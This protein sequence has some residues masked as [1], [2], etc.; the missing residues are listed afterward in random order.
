MDVI[1]LGSLRVRRVVIGAER[2]EKSSPVVLLMHGFGAPG[3][4]LV[5][6]AA[7]LGAA[8]GTTFLFPE[9][10]LDLGE[11]LPIYGGA[12]AWWMIDIARLERAI[13]TNEMR[14]LRHEIPEG[15]AE[16][17]EKV[18]AALDEIDAERLVIGGF[19]QGAMLATDVALHSTRPLSGLALLSGTFLCEDEWRPRMSSR[20]GLE[21]FQSHGTED[22]LLP[23]SLAAELRDALDSA[24][25]RVDFHSFPGGHAIPPTVMRALARWLPARVS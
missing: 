20:A 18:I 24:K 7:E 16:A 23:F 14:D 12:R 4:D 2:P 5:P 3:D 22:P 9:A 6:F 10:P 17:R 15:L 13:S 8:S 21:V 11:L 19:S 1:E 25:L